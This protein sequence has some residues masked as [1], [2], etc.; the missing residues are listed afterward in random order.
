MF[1]LCE[2]LFEEPFFVLNSVMVDCWA[3]FSAAFDIFLRP[4]VLFKL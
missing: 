4:E 2:I 3:G 1:K